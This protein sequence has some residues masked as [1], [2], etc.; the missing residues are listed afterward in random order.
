MDMHNAALFRAL[1]ASSERLAGPILENIG[2]E[3]AAPLRVVG[4]RKRR[5]LATRRAEEE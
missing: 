1:L 4:T 3:G 5:R 2:N